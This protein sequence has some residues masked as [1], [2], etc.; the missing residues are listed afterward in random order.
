MPVCALVNQKIFCVHGGISSELKSLDQIRNLE[1][2]G[3]KPKE[4][5][6]LSWCWSCLKLVMFFLLYMGLMNILQSYPGLKINT[7]YNKGTILI[8]YKCFWL[9]RSKIVR[10]K[11]ESTWARNLHP[12]VIPETES[13][14]YWSQHSKGVLNML[15]TRFDRRKKRDCLQNKLLLISINFTPKTSHS[16]TKKMELFL[17]FSRC[18]FNRPRLNSP[19]DVGPGTFSHLA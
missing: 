19:W 5:G 12:F 13:V 16:C 9:Y 3:K 8:L 4:V 2:R 15:S 1:R 10:V 7:W 14:I 18:T 17:W 11:C 6:H